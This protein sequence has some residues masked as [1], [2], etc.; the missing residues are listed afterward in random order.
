MNLPDHST[1]HFSLLCY[2]LLH[3]DSL[4]IKCYYTHTSEGSSSPEIRSETKKPDFLRSR[5]FCFKK[6]KINLYQLQ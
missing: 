3:I 5:A 4:I 6:H 1:S 2:I